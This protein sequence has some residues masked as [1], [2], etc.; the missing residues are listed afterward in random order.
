MC[1]CTKPSRSPRTTRPGFP[2]TIASRS[3]PTSGAV[4]PSP[5]PPNTLT[6]IQ[7]MDP[8]RLRIEQLRREAIRR[9]F[10]TIT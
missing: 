2:I 1:G 6:A 5:S 9:S 10:G 8:E 3:G 4:P 7:A